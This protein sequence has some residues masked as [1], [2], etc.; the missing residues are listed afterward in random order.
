MRHH[1]HKWHNNELP[2]NT[3]GVASLLDGR[4]WLSVAL[5]YRL[6]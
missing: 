5:E 6:A 3:A 2:D 1:H 4:D